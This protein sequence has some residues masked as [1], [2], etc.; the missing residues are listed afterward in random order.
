VSPSRRGRGRGGGGA[1]GAALACAMA[2]PPRVASSISSVAGKHQR[3]PLPQQVARHLPAPR[4]AP[5]LAVVR[6]G[7]SKPTPCAHLA[8]GGPGLDVH[9]AAARAEAEDGAQRLHRDQARARLV[10]VADGVALEGA[11]VR[12][13]QPVRGAARGQH[14]RALHRRDALRVARGRRAAGPAPQRGTEATM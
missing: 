7:R 5:A 9:A 6:A 2:R 13:Q 4:S 8:D 11:A 10:G 12:P 3:R 1:V 14:H